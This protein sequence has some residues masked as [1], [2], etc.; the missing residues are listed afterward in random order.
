MNGWVLLYKKIWDN[1]LFKGNPY[2]MSVWVWFLTH[3]DDNGDITCGRNQISRDTGVKPETVRYWTTR[4]LQENYQLITIKTTNKY[5]QYHICNFSKLQHPYTK[6]NTANIQENYQQTTTN[7]EQRIKN[8]DIDT[9]VSCESSDSPQNIKNLLSG[10][11]T[12]LGYGNNVKLTDGRIRKL[13][14]RLKQ[15]SSAD[16][17]SAAHRIA[18]DAFMQGDNT[19]GKRYGDIDYLL[20]SDEV[21]DKWLQLSISHDHGD[22][23]M[24]S[25]EDM[26]NYV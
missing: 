4:F 17:L 1:P 12:A 11:I 3:C 2:A 5:T 23:V 8:K 7:K 25:E 15:Y 26:K 22:K 20:R 16:L 6:K 9:N 24:I 18:D 19:G 13:K 10:L 14:I 21:V